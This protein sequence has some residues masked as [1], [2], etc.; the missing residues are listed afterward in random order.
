M[1]VRP[2][3]LWGRAALLEWPL[4]EDPRVAAATAGAFPPLGAGG[5]QAERRAGSTMDGEVGARARSPA[6]GVRVSGRMNTAITP[7]PPAP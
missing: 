6:D 2:M 1:C 4:V 5:P 3:C 7:H